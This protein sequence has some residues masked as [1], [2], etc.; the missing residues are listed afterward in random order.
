MTGWDG[1]MVSLTHG[2]E[3]EQALGVSD[4]QG[5]LVCC[6][7]RDHKESDMTERLT[8][9]DLIGPGHWWGV[10]WAFQ[11][12]LVV[13]SPPDNAGDIRNLGSIPGSGRPPGGGNGNTLQY[14]CLENPVDGGA[15]QGT[16]HRLTKSR[17]DTTDWQ[18]VCTRG[19]PF[20][21]LFRL[22][23][24]W[25]PYSCS[26]CERVSWVNIMIYIQDWGILSDLLKFFINV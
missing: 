1:W 17:S 18:P 4:G 23:N 6:S 12:A 19:V 9:N 21:L 10:S 26:Y 8:W 20:S 16:I 14:S 2:C 15:W 25:W 13:K 7:P 3:F 11:V 24:I 5:S 22:F